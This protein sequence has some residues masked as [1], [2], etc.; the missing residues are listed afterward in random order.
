MI[1]K[2]E[3]LS[4]T[5]FGNGMSVPGAEDISV[6][7]DGKGFPYYKG[8]TFK[9]VFREQ[10]ERYLGW[11]GKAEAQIQEEIKRLLGKEGTEESEDKLVF[12]DFTLS[13]YVKSEIEKEI[14]AQPSEI[15]EVLTNLRTF[16]KISEDGV[17]Q[18]GSL[19]IARCVDQGL[20]F[21]SEIIC[22]KED[23]KMIEEV[24]GTV[25]WIGSMRNRGFGKVRITIGKGAEA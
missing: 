23:E 17:A 5:I 18:K 20:I 19:R 21:Y 14:G 1:V 7:C 10:L 11:T 12:S 25:K 8:T 22:K 24:L 9:G 3:L 16:T 15:T 2:M 6:L 13:K 4:D